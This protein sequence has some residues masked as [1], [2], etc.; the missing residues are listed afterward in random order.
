MGRSDPWIKQFYGKHIK[1]EGSVALLGF[2]DNRF[3]DGD[4]YDLQ[5]GN[6][7]INS[8]WSLPK[9]YDTIICLR[10]PYFAKDPER[11]IIKCHEHL[12]DAGQLYVDWGLGDHWR[13]DNYKIGWKKDDEHEYCYGEENYLWAMIWDDSILNDKN[14]QVFAERVKKFGYEDTKK[15]IFQEIPSI[16]ELNFVANYFETCYNTLTLWEDNPQFYI[17]ISAKRKENEQTT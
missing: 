2:T 15:A 11:F 17:L 6:W 13:F 4:L 14:Y 7:D 1:P 12:N 5:L 9:K 16:I 10:C 3:F 8:D